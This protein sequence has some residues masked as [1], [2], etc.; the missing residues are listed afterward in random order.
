M[1]P[2]ARCSDKPSP[3]GLDVRS[4]KTMME[5]KGSD[6]E[7]DLR[8]NARQL[9]ELLRNTRKGERPQHVRQKIRLLKETVAKAR[10]A[11]RK[12]LTVC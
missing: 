3:A 7:E 5:L 1:F 10:A 2:P 6:W 11:R 8:R 9:K 4:P 12:V